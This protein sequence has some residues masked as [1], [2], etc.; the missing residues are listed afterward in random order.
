MAVS[1]AFNNLGSLSQTLDSPAWNPPTHQGMSDQDRK[2]KEDDENENFK[3]RL[4]QNTIYGGV[5]G[6][7]ATYLTK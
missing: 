7:G 3:S 6:A 4:R 1:G 5:I 2:N